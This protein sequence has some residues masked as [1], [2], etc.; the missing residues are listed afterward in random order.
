L[1]DTLL[2]AIVG[3]IALIASTWLQRRP[4]KTLKATKELAEKAVEQTEKTGN[5]FAQHTR[6][7][8]AQLHKSI[9]AVHR[10]LD[11]QDTHQSERDDFLDEVL[12]NFDNRM[13]HIEEKL[14]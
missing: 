14:Q 4:S 10:R 12:T 1:S 2:A 9:G 7:Q 8:L 11:H 3:A 6:D 13:I 5:G